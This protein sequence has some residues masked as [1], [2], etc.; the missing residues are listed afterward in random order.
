MMNQL[1]LKLLNRI[2]EFSRLGAKHTTIVKNILVTQIVV[3]KVLKW[4]IVDKTL[5]H[6]LRSRHP[7][8]IVHTENVHSLTICRMQQYNFANT[9]RAACLKSTNG[10]VMRAMG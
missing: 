3:S 7:N 4:N 10:T 5:A 9:L 8:Q 6:N 2:V 1:Q